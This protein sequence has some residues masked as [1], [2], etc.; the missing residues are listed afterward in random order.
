MSD[1]LS[2]AALCKGL[3]ISLAFL[4]VFA[5]VF[6][7]I[8]Y[9]FTITNDTLLL[10]G[11]I[12]LAVAIFAGAFSAARKA[13][14]KGLLHGITLGIIFLIVMIILTLLWGDMSWHILLEKA[15]LTILA[16]T[17]GGILGI[18]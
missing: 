14:K 7:L 2:I 8:A 17:I 3:F 1:R 11:N 13:G 12:T 9:F 10:L 18:R 16:G 6:S 5:L 15:G 4:L